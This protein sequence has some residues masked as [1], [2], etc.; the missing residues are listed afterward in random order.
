MVEII[1]AHA[2][3][4]VIAEGLWALAWGIFAGFGWGRLCE[5]KKHG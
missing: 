5:R 1:A 3:L 2:Q 4:V